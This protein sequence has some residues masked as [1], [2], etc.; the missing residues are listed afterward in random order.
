MALG[1]KLMK[2]FRYCLRCSTSLL[3]RFVIVT[4]T[5]NGNTRQPGSLAVLTVVSTLL[6]FSSVRLGSVKGV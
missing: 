3:Y 4:I 6:T 1:D 2:Y 5:L